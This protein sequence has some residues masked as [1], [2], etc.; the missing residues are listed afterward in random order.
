MVR[1]LFISL[2][3]FAPSV[4]LACGMP[5]SVAK[6]VKLQEAIEE[7]DVVAP[8]PAPAEVTP[9]PTAPPAP[10]EPPAAEPPAPVPTT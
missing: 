6:G 1:A 4:A 3:L 8:T 10:V 9:E 5:M 7:I 2:I